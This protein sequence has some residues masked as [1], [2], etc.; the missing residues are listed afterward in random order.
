M[1]LKWPGTFC[2]HFSQSVR[3]PMLNDFFMP[4]TW[5]QLLSVW[6][7]RVWPFLG[8]VCP[9]EDG[10]TS[11]VCS[12]QLDSFDV[13]GENSMADAA[14][15]GMPG[16]CWPFILG[17]PSSSPPLSLMGDGSRRFCT[18]FQSARAARSSERGTE[19]CA[20]GG[21]NPDGCIA[22]LPAAPLQLFPR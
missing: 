8:G 21:P 11:M 19:L 22:T 16:C 10:S 12:E 13:G 5:V 1:W 2:R 6:R 4:G 20:G 18:M 14:L 17:V 3:N 15:G 9:V 7:L